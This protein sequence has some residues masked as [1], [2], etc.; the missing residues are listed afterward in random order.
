MEG[1]NFSSFQN[2]VAEKTTKKKIFRNFIRR[3][4]AS[5]RREVLVNKTIAVTTMRYELSVIETRMSGTLA[6]INKMKTKL[7]Q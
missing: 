2:F 7:K 5:F 3:K 4:K 1:N 6:R